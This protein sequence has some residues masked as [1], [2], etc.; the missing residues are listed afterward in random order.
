[1]IVDIIDR[2]L[3][4]S[5]TSEITLSHALTHE[6][7][8]GGRGMD[9]SLSLVQLLNPET[10]SLTNHRTCS[11]QNVVIP[12]FYP[13]RHMSKYQNGTKKLTEIR[14]CI[15]QHMYKQWV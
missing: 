9:T 14:M 11:Q 13:S 6:R 15:F 12:Y 5:L 8:K 10:A 7:R 1:M 3:N 4:C 2:P